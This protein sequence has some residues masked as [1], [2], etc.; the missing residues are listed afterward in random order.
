[1]SI[2]LA[3]SQ[4]EIETIPHILVR[5][6]QSGVSGIYSTNF[7]FIAKEFYSYYQTSQG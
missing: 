6:P 5:I 4:Q 2:S 7:W 1:M 3:L